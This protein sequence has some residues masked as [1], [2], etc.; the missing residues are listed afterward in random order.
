M[1]PTRAEKRI[2]G[3]FKP[4]HAGKVHLFCRGCGRKQSNMERAEYDPSAAAIVDILCPKC[5]V[6]TKD[7]EVFY[8]DLQGKDIDAARWKKDPASMPGGE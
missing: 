5:S 7:P 4:L 3:G 8:Y 1:P 6:G 2:A